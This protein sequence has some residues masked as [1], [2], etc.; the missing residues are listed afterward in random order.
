MD[1]PESASFNET[2]HVRPATGNAVNGHGQPIFVMHRDVTSWGRVIRRPQSVA[3]PAY[4]DIVEDW[5]RQTSLPRLA[6]GARRSY[7][8][9]CLFSD[10]GS[11]DMC[12]LNRL[13]AFDEMSGI[14]TAEAGV[15]LSD[16]MT[17]FVPRGWFPV[18]TPGTRNVTLGG[19][20]AN[21]V[22]GK[23]HHKVG[24]FGN[25]VS[26]FTLVR[27]DRGVLRVDPRSE[28]Q[29]W[30]ATIGGLGLT[31]VIT[32]LSIQL[33]R[34]TSA[35]LDVEYLPFGNVDE[36]I[37][38]SNE[39]GDFEHTVAWLDCTSKAPNLGRGIY[40]R[41]RW[42]QDGN[43][44]PHRPSKARVPFDAPA[45]LL[46]SE[47]LR[48]FNALYYSAGKRKKG[49]SVAHYS[50]VLHPLDGV[51]NW[52]RLYG[53]AG[54]Y[55]YQ[56]VTP[57]ANGLGPIKALLDIISRSGEGSFLAVLKT[58]G[59]MP[60]SGFLSF[61]MPGYTLALDFRNRGTA[62]LELMNRLD[63]IVIAA[64]G[65]LYPAKD[66]R[67]SRR[68]FEQG[69]DHLAPFLKQRDPACISDFSKRIGL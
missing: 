58:F 67:I 29:L 28:P 13:L 9:S 38:V 69:F 56:C 41:A 60:S 36:F 68:M 45:F 20:L 27:S 42:R 30:G 52:N 3:A 35:Y 25:H 33:M 24:T 32:Q 8:D 21:D 15:L 57:K 2:N 6:T 39:S 48:L 1:T 7:G 61:P 26:S 49:L 12:Q 16:I 43:L 44:K 62:T 37:S 19:A 51:A 34:I 63:E 59:D 46:N 47:T 17:V 53:R 50:E 64:G 10:G 23:N 18:V 5:A 65:R 40:S 66:G 31:G 22:H 14:L 54:F 11:L 4:R 55:Q